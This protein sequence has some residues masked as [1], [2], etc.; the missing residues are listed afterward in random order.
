[1]LTIALS[2]TTQPGLNYTIK[3]YSSN[4]LT[5]KL[6]IDN[7]DLNDMNYNLPLPIATINRFN[8]QNPT[9]MVLYWNGTTMMCV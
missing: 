3:N 7:G 2:S 1:M 9:L 4:D 8:G 6:Q 5:I